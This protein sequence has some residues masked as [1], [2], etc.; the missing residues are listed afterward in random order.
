MYP[1]T[2]LFLWVQIARFAKLLS[3]RSLYGVCSQTRGLFARRDSRIL[4]FK[5]RDIAV[6][7]AKHLAPVMKS[8]EL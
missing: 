4:L 6:V 1:D 2:S 7:G 5:G 3:G 8:L